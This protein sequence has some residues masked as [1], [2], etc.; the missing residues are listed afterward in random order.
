MQDSLYVICKIESQIHILLFYSR[1]QTSAFADWIG[2]D[3][4]K[5]IDRTIATAAGSPD[6]APSI[7]QDGRCLSHYWPGLLMGLI[8]DIGSRLRGGESVRDFH[9]LWCTESVIVA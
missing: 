3:D 6:S 7:L 1:P 8:F 2:R 9:L 5:D 4:E